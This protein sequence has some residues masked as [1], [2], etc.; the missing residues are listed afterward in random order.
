MCILHTHGTLIR[1]LSLTFLSRLIFFYL[2]NCF[3]FLHL[4][5]HMKERARKREGGEGGGRK[6][7]NDFKLE[8]PLQFSQ[9]QDSE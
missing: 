3:T 6:E 2:L 8:T 1:C 4:Q 9:G 5:E 7:G